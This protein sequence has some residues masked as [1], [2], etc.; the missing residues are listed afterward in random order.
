M[1]KLL[2][3]SALVAVAPAAF[4]DGHITF[5][6]SAEVGYIMYGS[7]D[8]DSSDESSP[9][10]SGS[11]SVAMS[12][13]TDNG[14]SFGASFDINAGGY[15]NEGDFGDDDG[16]NAGNGGITVYIGSDVLMF[17]AGENG[18]DEYYWELA[19]ES[20][21]FTYALT[22][23]FGTDSG[24]LEDSGDDVT[25]LAL[26]YTVDALAFSASANTDDEWDIGVTYT[27]SDALV[28]GLSYDEADVLT[29]TVSGETAGFT[30]S[31]EAATD[32]SWEVALGYTVDAF[33][34]TAS[35][36]SDDNY[37]VEGTYDLGGGAVVFANATYDDDDGDI[38][39]SMSLGIRMS[40]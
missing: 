33:G 23:V 9:Y 25:S 8:E 7:D 14:L 19:G 2:I 36:D 22:N 20:G 16:D 12:G 15:N 1:K 34:I 13:E 32:D 35:T 21:G 29:G 27:V 4:A 3:T 24:D 37:S 30:Y 28:V 38:D 17:T 5:S 6:G 39:D 40:F 11:I 26:G 31:L 10:S 18:D